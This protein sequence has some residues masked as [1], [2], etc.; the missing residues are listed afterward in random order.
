MDCQTEG[1]YSIPNTLK[2]RTRTAGTNVT[3]STRRVERSHNSWPQQCKQERHIDNL[4]K[5][6]T[7]QER[8]SFKTK[9]K[10]NFKDEYL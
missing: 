8:K 7:P 1:W 2:E 9:N 3:K 6:T 10:N 4:E 5:W